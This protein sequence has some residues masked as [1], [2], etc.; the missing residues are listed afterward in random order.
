M[1]SSPTCSLGSQEE[2]PLRWQRGA[3]SELP[4]AGTLGSVRHE[5]HPVGHLGEAVPSCLDQDTWVRRS[6]LDHSVQ[7]PD[8]KDTDVGQKSVARKGMAWVGL[9]PDPQ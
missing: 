1:P 4:N 3:H 9:E 5:L 8:F 2:L 7:P 6:F